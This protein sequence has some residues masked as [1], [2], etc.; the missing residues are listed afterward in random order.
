MNPS[1]QVPAVK[2]IR[3]LACRKAVI[4]ALLIRHK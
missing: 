4:L 2:G 1:P 3:A